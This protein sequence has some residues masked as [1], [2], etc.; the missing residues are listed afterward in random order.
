MSFGIED[1][2]NFAVGQWL[3]EWTIVGIGLIVLVVVFLTI[4]SIVFIR[5]AIV[6]WMRKR[7][8]NKKRVKG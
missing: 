3:A 1:G 6:V 7:Q 4:Y 8:K 2:F 5:D